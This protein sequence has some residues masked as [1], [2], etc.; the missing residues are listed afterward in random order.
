MPV[1]SPDFVALNR[2]EEGVLSARLEAIRKSISH[3]G[4]KGRALEAQVQRVLRDMLPSEY[5]LKT[6][7]VVWN[8]P[9][10]LALS[11]QLDIIIYDAIRHSPLVHLE[12]C[13]VLPLEAVYAELR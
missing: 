13:D 9:S 11:P 6:G 1:H 5:G 12:S 3:A 10:G 8:S 2:I 7:F 4:E